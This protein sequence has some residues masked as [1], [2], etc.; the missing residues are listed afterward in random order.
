MVELNHS[1]HYLEAKKLTKRSEDPESTGPGF[2]HMA[3][4]VTRRLAQLLLARFLLLRLLVEEAQKFQ[5]GLQWEHHR[6]WVLLQ[7]QPKIIGR[8]FNEDIFMHLARL[9]GPAGILDL[10]ERIRSCHLELQFWLQPTINADLTFFCVLD[11]AQVTVDSEFGRLGEFVSNEGKTPRPIL[12]QIWDSWS[13]V[14]VGDM[15]LVLS[16]TGIDFKTLDATLT[17]S[18][19]KEANYFLVKDIGAFDDPEV[20]TAYIKRYVPLDN[21]CWK[22]FSIRACNWFRGR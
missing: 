2:Q 9:L 5:G 20:Q 16:G 1:R 14:L 13:M 3:D 21:Q 7:A 10:Q 18:I 11:E 17:S 4:K 19:F 22:E 6:L 8:I 12:R 15:C